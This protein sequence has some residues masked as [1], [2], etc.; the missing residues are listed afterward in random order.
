MSEESEHLERLLSERP[1]GIAG[2][3]EQAESDRIIAEDPE[4]AESS[5]RYE[6]LQRMLDGWRPLRHDVDWDAFKLAVSERVTEAA[7]KE[8]S[9]VLDVRIDAAAGEAAT[10]MTG[11]RLDKVARE[12]EAV[13]ELVEEWAGSVPE[14]D[15]AGFKHRVSQAVREEAA[16]LGRDAIL[17]G[18]AEIEKDSARRRWRKVSLRLASIGAPLAAAAAI[19][20]FVLW[21]HGSDVT[22]PILG[23][24]ASKIV[25][26]S[27]DVPGSAGR[28]SITFDEAP[29][30]VEEVLP[31]GGV[32]MAITPRNSDAV[33]P[34]DEA[35][36][37]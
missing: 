36:F 24:G 10:E 11:P 37:Y 15:W 27:L 33:E 19:A 1:D 5:R 6:R 9:A 34:L 22:G 29:A 25:L 2:A 13:E 18:A 28:I 23:G 12:Y 16:R 30:G 17:E 20:I 7:E 26:V 3:D 14:V 4:S 31:E 32:A 21:P 35:F 8:A